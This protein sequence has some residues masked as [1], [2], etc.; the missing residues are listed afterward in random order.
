MFPPR[1]PGNQTRYIQLTPCLFSDIHFKQWRI[2]PGVVKDKFGVAKES[3]KVMQ[4]IVKL[5][6][7]GDSFTFGYTTDILIN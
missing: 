5:D 3:V 2:F 7:I 4:K 6:I 1:L